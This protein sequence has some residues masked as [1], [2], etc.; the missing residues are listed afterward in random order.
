MESDNQA[1]DYAVTTTPSAS[2][3]RAPRRAG[4]V[5]IILA[6]AAALAPGCATDYSHV[7]YVPSD[8]S[9]GKDHMSLT[10]FD[11]S[12]RHAPSNHG[13]L[14][15]YRNWIEMP[16][17]P[18]NTNDSFWVTYS[19]TSMLFGILQVIPAGLD[20]FFY[21]TLGEPENDEDSDDCDNTATRGAKTVSRGVAY[22]FHFIHRLIGYL[23]DRLVGGSTFNRALFY[24]GSEAGGAYEGADEDLRTIHV[25][26]SVIV[27]GAAAGG[28]G[29]SFSGDSG[30]SRSDV[31][32]GT[33]DPR[34]GGDQQNSNGAQ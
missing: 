23:G 15:S 21:G 26:E 3:S 7:R 9:T 25:I 10:L 30:D 18:E 12:V 22:P 4:L 27:N 8:G 24:G 14:Q 31:N 19:P 11:P 2:S 32:P 29:A 5:G 1:H 20:R 16:N 13:N 33:N 6:G 28:A 17:R 34:I